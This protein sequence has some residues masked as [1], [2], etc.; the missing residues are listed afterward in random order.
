M[1]VYI[2]VY[3]FNSSFPALPIQTRGYRVLHKKAKSF[4]NDEKKGYIVEVQEEIYFADTE[5]IRQ[6]EFYSFRNELEVLNSILSLID[7]SLST[8][9]TNKLNLLRYLRDA[10]VNL[11]N[12]VGEN[13]FLDARAIENCK[14]EQEK[15]LLHWSESNGT[16]TELD[17]AY[18]EGEGRGAL[19]TRDLQVGDI[20]LEIP[21]SLIISEDLVHV[22]DMF[23]VLKGIDGISPE[24][25]LLLWSMKEKD[26][27]N[28]K[29]K[30]YFD[31]LPEAFNTGLSFRFDAI[32]ALDG[33]LLMEEIVQA[34]EHLR[35]QY[36]ELFPALCNNYP[37]TF[38][39]ELY[40]WE[41]FLWA[42][43]LWYSNGMKVMFADGKLK[44]C[45]I[46]V[47]GFLNHSPCPHIIH[48][49]KVD[50]STNTL[51]F[52]LSRPCKV[53]E[54]CY[55]SYGN[56]PSSHLVTFYGF[57]PQGKNPYD[58]IPLDIDGAR[59]DYSKE[60]STLHS[61]SIHMVRATW[62]SSNHGMFHYGLPPPLL[63]H[64]RKA[65]N[66]DLRSITTFLQASLETEMEVLEILHSTFHDMME[67]LGYMGHEAG[68]ET[69]WDV[70]LALKFK[71]LQRKIVLSL[72]SSCSAGKKLVETEFLKC[73]AED[74]RG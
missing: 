49:G 2:Y 42:C 29:F 15:R 65:Q 72:L 44:T 47:A 35:N 8:C 62:F 58:I 50:A 60:D 34:K 61:W 67:N 9:T 53:G 19:A 37:D 31:T 33:T 43:E 46:P 66:P 56:F 5:S 4:C 14:C 12:K 38:P 71:D 10:T 28:S 64:L 48:Y 1:C 51:K 39:R 3:I 13:S 11:I 26:N 6:G 22:S 20:A 40:T 59:A 45:L 17:V 41:N 32:M 36:D 54:E 73:M 25:M 7:I 23:D 24:T 63:A 27:K 55:L 18:F 30:I 16:K 52:P 68:D 69:N 74:T 57:L 70:I 21:V